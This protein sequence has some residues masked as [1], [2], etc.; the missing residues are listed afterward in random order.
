MVNPQNFRLTPFRLLPIPCLKILR[1]WKQ[2]R[3]F[4]PYYNFHRGKAKVLW[5]VCFRMA[6]IDPRKVQMIVK[7]SFNWCL[8]V[9]QCDRSI[10]VMGDGKGLISFCNRRL[11]QA[12]GLHCKFDLVF[13][14]RHRNALKL[15]TAL[16]KNYFALRSKHGFAFKL[17]CRG[18]RIIWKKRQW[19]ILWKH[20][21]HGQ[22]ETPNLVGAARA[23]PTRILWESIVIFLHKDSMKSDFFKLLYLYPHKNLLVSSKKT[24]PLQ[25]GQNSVLNLTHKAM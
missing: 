23:P 18:F 9:H 3:G 5:A 6:V 17:A 22:I 11:L 19:L 2:G 16:G 25:W 14:W 4:H 12:S 13:K 8:L 21:P 7:S 15:E 10:T 20:F 24:N 1:A